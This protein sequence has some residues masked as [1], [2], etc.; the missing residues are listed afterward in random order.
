MTRS[1]WGRH[2]AAAMVSLPFQRITSYRLTASAWMRWETARDTPLG[3]IG[4][5]AVLQR[6]WYAF[7]DLT[8]QPPL[9]EWRGGE[10]I[11]NSSDLVP[12]RP[13]SPFMVHFGTH[14]TKRLVFSPM[15]A[16]VGRAPAVP[17]G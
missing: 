14:L 7:R 3:A 9:H 1:R 2:L 15:R 16:M 13:P 17:A 10:K 12:L 6:V 8:P 4:V 11:D 5:R